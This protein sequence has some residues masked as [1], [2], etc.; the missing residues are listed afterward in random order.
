MRLDG[1]VVSLDIRSPMFNDFKDQGS[2]EVYSAELRGS[3][4]CLLGETPLPS[5]KGSTYHS[6]QHRPQS[7]YMV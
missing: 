7:H 1:A 5:P 6:S 4:A 2:G 3:W